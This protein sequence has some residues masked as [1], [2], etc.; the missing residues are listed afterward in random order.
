MEFL[1][2]KVGGD[3]DMWTLRCLLQFFLRSRD[4][5]SLKNE[6]EIWGQIRGLASICNGEDLFV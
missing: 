6:Q 2:S 5:Q 1:E 4:L 3:G